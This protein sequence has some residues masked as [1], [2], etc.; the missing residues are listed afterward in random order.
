MLI[1]AQ[2]TGGNPKLIARDKSTGAELA[3][4]DLPANPGGAP[5]SYSVDGKQFIALSLLST[6]VPELVIYAL[7]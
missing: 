7:Q 5:M 2:N 1:H 6:P 3:S 4:I